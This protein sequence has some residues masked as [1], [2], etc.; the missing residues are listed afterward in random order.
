M[1]EIDVIKAATVAR[2]RDIATRY[3]DNQAAIAN[4][5]KDQEQ[6]GQLAQRCYATAELFGFDL[7]AEVAKLTAIEQPSQTA[8][9]VAAASATMTA[10]TTVA[11]QRP[12]TIR[13]IIVEAARQAFPRAVRSADLRRQLQSRGMSVHEKTVGMTLYRLSREQIMRREGKADWFFVPDDQRK[14]ISGNEGSPGGD[15]PGDR[16]DIFG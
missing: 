5:T 13:E 9:Q 15:A 16:N 12:A 6:L 8:V 1:P 2:F 10:V 4:L 14:P 11:A 3:A 7:L